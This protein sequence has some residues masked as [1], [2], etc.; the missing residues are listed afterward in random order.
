[1][2]Q[3]LIGAAL[4]LVVMAILSSRAAEIIKILPSEFYLRNDISEL[5]NYDNGASI[6]RN[7]LDSEEIYTILIIDFIVGFSERFS[8]NALGS[9]SG[10]SSDSNL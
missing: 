1:M 2:L 5:K 4:S 7:P 6:P 9:I 10:A 8:R 3:P